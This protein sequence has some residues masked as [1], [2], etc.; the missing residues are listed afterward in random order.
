[1]FFS[2]LCY[3]VYE[4]MNGKESSGDMVEL[5]VVIPVY[6][7]VESVQSTLDEMRNTFESLENPIDYE[8]IVV[9]DGS[10]DGTG[11]VLESAK[12]IRLVTHEQNRGYGA[13]LKTGIRHARGEVIAIT[14]ADGTYPNWMIPELYRQKQSK[15]LDMIVASRTGKKAHIPL[16]RRPPKWVLNRLA[17]YLTSRKIPDLNS[18]LRL[19]GRDDSMKYFNIISDGF[20]FTTTITLAMLVNNYNVSFVPIEYA[21]RKGSSKIKP[22]RDTF[23]FLVLIVRTIAFF[24]PLKIFIPVSLLVFLLGMIGLVSQIVVGNVGDISVILLLSALQIFFIGIL[25]DLI[26]RKM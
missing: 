9:D 26:T 21:P 24:N 10:S 25:A 4:S 22:V 23:N 1:M 3:Q 20:S 2:I 16:L 11:K 7:E 13:S 19:F 18:G 17:N 15:G 14:D 12:H 8:V 5:S 6:N